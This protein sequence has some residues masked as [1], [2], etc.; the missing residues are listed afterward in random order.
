MRKDMSPEELSYFATTFAVTLSQGLDPGSM[1]VLCS[2]F[3]CVINTL[4]LISSQRACI[5]KPPI[6][7]PGPPIRPFGPP[8]HPAGPPIH[9]AGPVHHR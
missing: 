6:H 1:R 2:F 9:P 4:N 5:E 7:P 3:Y 8:I